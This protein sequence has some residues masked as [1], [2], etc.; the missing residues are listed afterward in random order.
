M[1]DRQYKNKCTQCGFCCIMENC[2]IAVKKFNIEQFGEK[3]PA[4]KFNDLGVASCS[5]AHTTFHKVVLGIGVGCCIKARVYMK[6][7]KYDFSSQP[8][9]LKHEY[10]K[11]ALKQKYG[12]IIV[13]K[14]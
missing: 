4:L 14:G 5:L 1:N 9:A 6:G 11:A 10:A 13:V 2:P 8:A 3:C 7:D 12:Q